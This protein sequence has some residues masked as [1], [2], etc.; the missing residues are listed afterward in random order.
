MLDGERNF[1]SPVQ[2]DEID[3]ELNQ[4]KKELIKQ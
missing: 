1:E 4:N 2:D 3:R